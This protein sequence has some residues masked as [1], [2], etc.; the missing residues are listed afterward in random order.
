VDTPRS[1]GASLAAEP[2][3]RRRAVLKWLGRVA[4]GLVALVVLL[5]VAG[6]AYQAIAS[7]ADQRAFP[8]PGQLVDVGGYSLH[9]YCLG[10]G[11]QADPTVILDSLNGGTVSN[12]AWVQQEVGR[13]A[14][15]CAYDRDGLGWSGLSPTPLDTLQ[16]AEALNTLLRRAGVP[17][18]YVLVGHSL[19]G[20]YARA[21]ADRFPSDVVGMVLVEATN[22]DFL[23]VQG[24]PDVLPGADPGMLDAGPTASRFGLLRLVKF[25]SPPPDLPERQRDELAAYYSSTAFAETIRRQYYL[26]PTLLAQVRAMGGIGDRPLEVVLGT[27]G[28]GGNEDLRPLF[29]QQAALSTNSLTRRVEGATH[30]GLVTTREHALETSQ[31]ILDVLDAVRSGQP[32]R[33]SD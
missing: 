27:E 17:G 15:V 29:D 12:W 24:K 26:F 10:D 7:A 25:V 19:G 4:G 1:P 28:D 14:R 23:K 11:G 31:A 33:E 30:V 9:L 32:I 20:L 18:P 3:S 5:G 22:P 21:Y 6:L 8:P 16:N 2:P 13:H